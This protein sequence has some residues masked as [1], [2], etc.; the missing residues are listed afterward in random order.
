MG[1]IGRLPRRWDRPLW[2]P[3]CYCAHWDLPA[4][5]YAVPRFSAKTWKR[6]ARTVSTAVGMQNSVLAVV[7]AR[8]MGAP[9]LLGAPSA[10]VHSC[11]GSLMAAVWRIRG[12]QEEYADSDGNTSTNVWTNVNIRCIAFML[13]RSRSRFVELAISFFISLLGR[14]P[15]GRG[16]F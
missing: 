3:S 15:V 11:I 8:A 14:E 9:E 13:Q 7:L 5:G 4:L 10:T 16:S 12:N 1:G 2:H 6:T